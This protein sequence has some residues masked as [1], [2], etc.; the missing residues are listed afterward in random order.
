MTPLYKEALYWLI[1][2]AATVLAYVMLAMFIG[3]GGAC[4][5][6][7]LLGLA[8][9]LPLV[10]RKRGKAVILDERDTLDRPPCCW[11]A[12]PSSGY[13]S[14]WVSP[15]FGPRS[16]SAERQPFRF[17]SFPILFTCGLVVFMTARAV[18]ILVAVS[19]SKCGE[20]GISGHDQKPT[21]PLAFRARRNDPAGTGPAGRR[22]PAN[23]YRHRRRQI[24]SVAGA[25]LPPG[26]GVRCRR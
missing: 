20:G 12:T 19:P 1:L 26:P 3:T 11:P 14:R 2:S 18:A 5:A 23:D 8:G 10:Y 9:F 15:A 6:F 22:D 13:S 25:G 17:T 7:G 21:P 4:G 16:F 24:H